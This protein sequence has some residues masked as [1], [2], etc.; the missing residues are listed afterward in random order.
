[1]LQQYHEAFLRIRFQLVYYGKLIGLGIVAQTIF[2]VSA[3]VLLNIDMPEEIKIIQAWIMILVKNFFLG[4]FHKPQI[5]F[6]VPTV[7]YAVKT[8]ATALKYPFFISFAGWFLPYSIHSWLRNK[9]TKELKEHQVGGSEIIPISEFIKKLKKQQNIRA[10]FCILKA[11]L[12][13]V[14]YTPCFLFHCII[15]LLYHY[16]LTLFV[17]LP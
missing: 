8:V 16:I 10:L 13:N 11:L 9:E 17:H 7:I 2:F 12:I 4:I 3:I 14:L 15:L 5:E 1:M 6:D